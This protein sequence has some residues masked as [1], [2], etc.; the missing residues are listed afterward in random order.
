MEFSEVRLSYSLFTKTNKII[1]IANKI[2]IICI[3]LNN[4]IMDENKKH[5]LNIRLRIMG[6]TTPLSLLKSATEAFRYKEYSCV[7]WD[8]SL[9]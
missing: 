4:T 5:S 1:K 7:Y 3:V 6:Y 2:K 8:R 9:A